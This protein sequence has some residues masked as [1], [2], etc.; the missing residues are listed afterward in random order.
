MKIL[1][2]IMQA[3][4]SFI[5]L[6]FIGTSLHGQ[7]LIPMDTWRSHFNYEQTSLVE[8]TEANVFAATSHGL[9]YFDTE[10]QSINKLSKVD[11]LSDVGIT[12]LAYYADQAYLAIGYQNGNVDMITSEGIQNLPIL[13]NS[14]LTEN[15]TI[16]HISFYNANMN[17]ST[18][19]GVLVLT[20]DN[21]VVEAYQNLGENGEVIAVRSSAI[22]NEVMYLATETGT[23]A[24]GLNTSNNLQDFNNWERYKTSAVYGLDMVSV[25]V[26]NDRIYSAAADALYKLEAN[27]WTE[28]PTT[29]QAG[30]QIIKLRSGVDGLLVLTNQHAWMVSD[31]DVFSSINLPSEAIANDMMQDDTA[32]FWYADGAEG[33][34]RLSGSSVD[35]I[36]L[37]GPLNDISKLKITGG[38]VYA[39]PVLAIDYTQPV[40]NQLGYSFFEEGEWQTVMPVDL[41]GFTNISDVLIVDDQT[42]TTS[43]GQGILNL[44]KG[45]K[46]DYTNSA[47][48]E[49]EN[50]T[51]NT[52]VSAMALDRSQ[53]IWVANFSA[54]SLIQW[55]GASVW[56]AYDFGT[57]SS[58]E[59]VSLAIH[60]LGQVWM[61]L[62]LQD[63]RGVL[64]YDIESATHRYVTATATSLPS[65]DVNDLAFGQ[66]GEVWLATD[67]GVAY[68]PFAYGIVEDQTIDVSLPVYEGGILFEDKQ[69]YALAIDGGNRIWMGTQD[70]LWLFEENAGSL[71]AHFTVEN[72]PLPSNQVIDLALD[73]E[74]G[75][76]FIAT[77]QGVVSYRANATSGSSTHQQVKIY[78]NPVLPNFEGWVGFSGLVTN[79]RLKITT[80]SGQL[81]REVNAAGGG[82][83]WDVRDFSG[84]RVSTGVY[85]VFSASKDG[86]ETFVG[87]IAVID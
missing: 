18:D 73:A 46:T 31:T 4:V 63:G 35:H 83:S 66:G 65:N 39:F 78:P 52:L 61:R 50:G 5:I 79:A 44:P 43:F 36:I 30:E 74:T 6:L 55:D 57:V 15:K 59:P 45:E 13:L 12:A 17:L 72:S 16:N 10:D 8:K 3:K 49:N 67:K 54:N 26:A 9:M 51:G 82:A 14:D 77:D 71:V 80:I 81:V 11:G 64:A 23:I 69:V 70:G 1:K 19:F 85:L 84:R 24:G 76:L 60:S 37:D 7:E 34:S 56:E 2:E 28:V 25:A 87:K 53:N 75:E 58:E 47:L 20:A 38:K 68:F 33:L 86:S 21:Q 62:G 32:T 42:Y 48:E 27:T 29:L 40:S 22:W 41:L